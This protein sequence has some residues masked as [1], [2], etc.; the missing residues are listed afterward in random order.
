MKTVKLQGIHTPQPAI[1]ARELKPGMTR[2]YNYGEK[3]EI[4]SVVPSKT[5]KT[6]TVTDLENG[7]EY[8]Y[9]MK[10]GTLVAVVQQDAAPAPKKSEE[11]KKAIDDLERENDEAVQRMVYQA[12]GRTAEN[13][14]ALWKAYWE[15]VGHENHRRSE[16]LRTE[17]LAQLNREIE[18]GDGVTMYLY[19][20]SHACTVISRTEKTLTI[21][22]DKATRD[23][24]FKPEWVPGGFSAIC[25]NNDQQKWNCEPDP[26]GEII[27]CRWSEKHGCWQT[28]SDGSIRIGRG[29]HERHDYNF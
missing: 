2:L 7:K 1:E 14:D 19:S 21:Q 3:G 9:R 28:G 25:V 29:R 10:A 16:N 5:G 20:D 17:L 11:I 4:V 26:N 23:P 27:K 24:S 8:T 18:V 22:R 15:A 13:H 6:V 12:P